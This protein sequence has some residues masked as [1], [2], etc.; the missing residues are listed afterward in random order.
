[1][2]EPKP[3]DK[4]RKAMKQILSVPKEELQRRETEYQ[5]ERKRKKGEGKPKLRK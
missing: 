4:F 2:S 1:M 3:S 5:S